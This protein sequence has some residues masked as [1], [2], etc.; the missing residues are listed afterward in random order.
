MATVTT[1]LTSSL[2]TPGQDVGAGILTKKLTLAAGPASG[3]N[4]Q[5][6]TVSRNCRMS[7]AHLRVAGTLGASCTI[8][9][10]KNTGGTRSDLTIATTA[11]GASV[12]S[13]ATIGCID[14][15]AGDIIELL[16]GGASV[17]TG[18]AVEVDLVIDSN[19]AI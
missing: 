12:V 9:L 3:D 13:S 15:V 11:A 7:A 19:R 8:K 2:L 5:L 17:G 10:Q 6:F 18:A 14:L 16:V 4:I 1:Y